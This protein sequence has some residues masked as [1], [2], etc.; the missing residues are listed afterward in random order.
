M[1]TSAHHSTE[2]LLHFPLDGLL[3][4]AQALI[5]NPTT[6]KAILLSQSPA[7]STHLVA[8]QHFSPNSMRVLLP[9]LATYP[10]YCAYDTILASLFAVSL[11]DA[12]LLRETWE[13]AIRPIRRAI[14]SDAI[15]NVV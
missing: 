14:S 12:R 3:P 15:P 5:V 7:A 10:H 9:L 11:E 8:Q 13:V 1:T 4:P 6:R 2:D